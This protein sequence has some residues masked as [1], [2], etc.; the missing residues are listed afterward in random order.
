MRVNPVP[1]VVYFPKK[2]D[3]P[4]NDPKSRNIKKKEKK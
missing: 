3:K 4:Q 2:E 1:P